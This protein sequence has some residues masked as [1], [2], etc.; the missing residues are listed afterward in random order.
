MPW[1]MLAFGWAI[2]VQRSPWALVALALLLGDS[3][4]LPAGR[5]CL[6]WHS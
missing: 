1:I 2:L 4:L 3:L 6:I 5:V